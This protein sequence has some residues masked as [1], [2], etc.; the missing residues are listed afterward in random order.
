MWD[1]K[2]LKIKDQILLFS[3]ALDSKFVIT[4]MEEKQPIYQIKF[5]STGLRQMTLHEDMNMVLLRRDQTND[6]FMLHFDYSAKNP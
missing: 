4:S 1:L 3:T 5:G 2:F 6:V